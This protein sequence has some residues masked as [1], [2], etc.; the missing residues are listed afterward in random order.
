MRIADQELQAAKLLVDP[1]PS[2]AAYFV[3]Q[4]AEKAARAVLTRANVPFGRSH[5][6]EQMAEALPANHPLQGR[7]LTLDRFSGA[8]TRYRYPSEYG[9]ISE[10]PHPDEVKADIAEVEAFIVVVKQHV[11]PTPPNPAPLRGSRPSRRA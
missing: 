6:L 4:A 11:A 3:Q 1:L 10:A 2:Q 7:I 5:N 8:A 9:N